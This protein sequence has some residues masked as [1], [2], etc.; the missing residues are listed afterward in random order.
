MYVH[1]MLGSAKWSADNLKEAFEMHGL[2]T[3]VLVVLNSRYGLIL[4]VWLL[5]VHD[6]YPT[7]R[8]QM[9]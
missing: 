3:R 7:M 1:N 6:P 2:R 8:L 9:M 5:A 4:W